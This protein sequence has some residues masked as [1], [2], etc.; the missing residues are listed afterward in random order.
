MKSGEIH[1]SVNGE[2]LSIPE[3]STL[4]QVLRIAEA[5]YRE[6]ASVGIVRRQEGVKASR[7]KE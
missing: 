2:N 4:G 6:G 1:I 5:P 7:V 3:G